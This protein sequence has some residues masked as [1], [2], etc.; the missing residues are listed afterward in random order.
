MLLKQYLKQLGFQH[1]R[2]DYYIRI[3]DEISIDLIKITWKQNYFTLDLSIA[4]LVN[5]LKGFHVI[6]VNLGYFVNPLF[7]TY[8][9]KINTEEM[10]SAIQLLDKIIHQFWPQYTSF[11][12]ILDNLEYTKR[13]SALMDDNADIWDSEYEDKEVE[14]Y[15]SLFNNEDQKAKQL[16][17]ELITLAQEDPSKDENY[18]QMGLKAAWDSFRKGHNE[19]LNFIQKNRDR[20]LLWIQNLRNSDP[21]DGFSDWNRQWIY[22][23]YEKYY[24]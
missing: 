15:F 12:T 1:L 9:W 5:L 4:Y 24:F 6:S 11:K 17:A 14:F 3:R 18:E 2:A 19:Y 23:Y 22:Y 7:G 16:Y 21:K 20:I 13:H 8:W 10:V